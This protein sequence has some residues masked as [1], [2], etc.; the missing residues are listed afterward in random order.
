[1]TNGRSYPTPI[2]EGSATSLLLSTFID[3]N[4]NLNLPLTKKYLTSTVGADIELSLNLW[5]CGSGID[6]I[7]ELS[8]EK[9]VLLMK[10]ERDYMSD[11]EKVWLI[12]DW[13]SDY[14]HDIG[15][16][17]GHDNDHDIGHNRIGQGEGTGTGTN[18]KNETSLLS[19]G[20]KILL[21]MNHTVPLTEPLTLMNQQHHLNGNDNENE[22]AHIQH[23]RQSCRT[24][25][26]Y[27]KEVNVIMGKQLHN[28]DNFI[29]EQKEEEQTRKMNKKENKKQIIKKDKFESMNK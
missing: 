24:F 19:I 27:T 20:Q 13:M 6:I 25:D 1:L 17:N 10:G 3:L 14:D 5:L 4:A 16:D 23:R 18:I 8:V 9:D 22:N 15:H 28:F 21:K 12:S 29:K 7:S 26:W 11:E 2:L